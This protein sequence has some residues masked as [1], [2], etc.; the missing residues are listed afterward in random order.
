LD[1]AGA[2]WLILKPPTGA[3]AATGIAIAT[4]ICGGWLEMVWAMMLLA[5]DVPSTPQCGQLTATGIWPLTGSTS[6][7]YFWPQPHSTF[8]SI[9]NSFLNLA[10]G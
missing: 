8:N 5:V 6:N 7:L 4:G 10:N 9:N 2:T 3:A 1:G